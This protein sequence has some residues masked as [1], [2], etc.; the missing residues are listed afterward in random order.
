MATSAIA[1]AYWRK[2]KSGERTWASIPTDIMRG[3]VNTL[4]MQEI[5]DGTISA[6]QYAELIGVPTEV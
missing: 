4:A 2:I 3:D 5:V 6:E 1:S